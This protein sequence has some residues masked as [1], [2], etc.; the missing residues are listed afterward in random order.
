[1]ITRLDDLIDLIHDARDSDP[2]SIR[3]WKKNQDMRH[4]ESMVAKH[5]KENVRLCEI[6][7]RGVFK[8][9]AHRLKVAGQEQYIG[10]ICWARHKDAFKGITED[11][12][13]EKTNDPVLDKLIGRIVDAI[14]EH[15]NLVNEMQPVS[16][17]ALPPQ[18]REA[19]EQAMDDWAN[20]RYGPV[21]A[22]ARE[23]CEGFI[24]E[25]ETAAGKKL[26]AF[27]QYARQQCQKLEDMHQWF[28]A[29]I[30]SHLGKLS[31]PFF[32]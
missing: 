29:S 21:D 11:M 14:N 19:A 6:C 28:M 15:K 22:S 10:P 9:K 17:G 8:A 1:M 24:G 18:I 5:G 7:W 2:I 4:Y 31:A 23:I 27:H 26:P 25:I 12:M 20:T 16:I 3:A 32:K 30:V 13:V